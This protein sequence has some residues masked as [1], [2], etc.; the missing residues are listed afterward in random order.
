MSTRTNAYEMHF[1][2]EDRERDRR[3]A[4]RP[5]PRGVEDF[6]EEVA[7]I[8]RQNGALKVRAKTFRNA[9]F[10]DLRFFLRGTDGELYP[11][12]KGVSIRIGEAE[13][14]AAAISKA[15]DLLAQR[16]GGQ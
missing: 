6:E 11:T 5:S 9:P 14:I 7:T 10:I 13:D 12:G 8:E 3:S 15:V 16:A 4:G 2:K 1:G